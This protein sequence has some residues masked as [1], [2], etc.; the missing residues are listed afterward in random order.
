MKRPRRATYATE[1]RSWERQGSEEQSSVASTRELRGEC[2]RGLLLGRDVASNVDKVEIF[3]ALDAIDHRYGLIFR[4]QDLF[5][6]RRL[7]AICFRPHE[8]DRGDHLAILAGTK[9]G[10]LR[11]VPVVTAEQRA[12]VDECK[13]IAAREDSLSG[14]ELPL[15]A[16]RRRYKHYAEKLGITRA[17]LGVTGHGLRHGYLHRRYRDALGAEVP[18]RGGSERSPRGAIARQAKRQLAEEMGHSRTSVLTAYSGSEGQ[19][20]G[21]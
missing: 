1:D 12:L 9:G 6:L 15:K 10:R 14:K 21:T 3:A 17:R 18:V 8:D 19:V 13:A 11:R 5:G 2:D 4:M 16:A 20:N 7:E